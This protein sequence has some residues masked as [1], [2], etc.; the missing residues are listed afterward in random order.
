MLEK[1]LWTGGCRLPAMSY[2]R[3]LDGHRLNDWATRAV[4]ELS[5]RRAE[6]NALNVFPVPDA[7]TGSNMTHTM[8]AALAEVNKLES[9]E[10]ISLVAQA[11]AVG[12]V[13]G[14]RGNSGLVL[15]QVLRAIASSATNGVIDSEAI[16]RA[17]GMAVYL[18]DR[19]IADPVEGTIITVLR[20]S[21]VAAGADDGDL[22]SVVAAAVAAARKAL[23]NTPSQLAVLRDAGVVDAGGAGLLVLLEA[24]NA[25]IEGDIAPAPA[26]PEAQVSDTELEVMFFFTGDLEEL[27]KTLTGMGNSLILARAD[28]TSANV[29]IH[30]NTAG[31]VIEAAFA[32]GEV[33]NLRLE[34]LPEAPQVDVLRRVVVAVTPAGSVAELYR[35]A[36]AVVVTPGED[37]VGDILS[38]VRTSSAEELILLPNGLLNR[39][40]LVSLERATHAFEQTIT[41]VPTRRLVTGIAA[42]SVHDPNEPVG[43]AAYAMSEAAAAMRTAVVA[44]TDIST[45]IEDAAI[46][47]CTPLLGN[48]AEQV[49]LLSGRDID[50]ETLDEALGLDVMVFPADGLG[51]LVEIGVE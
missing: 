35:Q 51:N 29:H 20:A 27:E 49:I 9:T 46:R 17:L 21:A 32:A 23:A 45:T 13:R 36:G 34:V 18:V 16:A 2:P 22:H 42:L 41:I 37:L 31:P 26:T 12:S 4:A 15:S 47:A 1:N 28:D 19:A 43:V 24:L 11:L 33:T 8:E 25:E 30:S 44:S 50:V 7:D 6:I 38:E 14:A 39:R 5:S 10:D 3:E 48:G 40:Q